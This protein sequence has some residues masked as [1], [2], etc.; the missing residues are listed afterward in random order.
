MA[1][2]L[3]PR[4][5]TVGVPVVVV[6]QYGRT[7]W[8]QTFERACHKGLDRRGAGCRAPHQDAGDRAHE[9]RQRRLGPL[10]ILFRQG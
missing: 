1:C 3:M 8:R 4:L 2:L 7:H 6:A 9:L 10:Q 5:A